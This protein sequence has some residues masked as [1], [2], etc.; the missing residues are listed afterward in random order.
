MSNILKNLIKK[1][2]KEAEIATGS[3]CTT[4]K[5]CPGGCKFQDCNGGYCVDAG[6]AP[7]PTGIKGKDGRKKAKR[8]LRKEAEVTAGDEN[9]K[10]NLK[11]DVSNPQSETKLGVRIQL[12]PK[13]GFLE[14]EVQDSLET[15]LMKKLNNALE[16]FDIQ[17]SKDTDVPDPT[18]IGFFIPLS[19]IKNMIVKSIKGS[20]GSS[21]KPDLEKD[22]LQRGKIS[23]MMDKEKKTQADKQT[24]NESVEELIG[25]Q[26]ITEMR[27]RTLNEISQIVIR[28]DFYGFVNAGNNMLRS[29]EERGY[30]M[31]EAKKYLGYLVKHNI[32]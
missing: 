15:A 17:V 21:F 22:A 16:Q 26:L 12:E 8:K 6:S 1:A 2:L 5:D 31:R 27:Q 32:M 30:D 3:E 7:D 4:C 20:G 11:V 13:E 29:L 24:T 14:P 19:Q 23:Q 10:F 28:E 25:D 18:V 9:T